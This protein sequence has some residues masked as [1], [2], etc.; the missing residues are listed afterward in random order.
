M[1]YKPGV[2]KVVVKLMNP[3]K[4]T[5][6]GLILAE[7]AVDQTNRGTVMAVGKGKMSDAGVVIDIPVSVNDVVMFS[8]G[9]GVVVAIDSEEMLV[10][11]EEDIF[12]IV[13]E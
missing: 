6:G 13:E 8:T 2:G 3:E 7:T 1:D 10:L 5:A 4:T 12:A 11:R 9:A